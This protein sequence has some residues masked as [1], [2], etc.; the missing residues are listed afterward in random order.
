MKISLLLTLLPAASMAFTTPETQIIHHHPRGGDF[1]LQNTLDETA[2]SC[3]ST[4]EK[5]VGK[6]DDVVLNRAMR[7]V[8][9]AP[10]F[11]TLK[12]LAD[13]AG[14]ELGL[15]PAAISALLTGTVD[16]SCGVATAMA[17]PAFM[18]STV[19]KAYILFAGLSLA[20]SA[21]ANDSNELSQADITAATAANFAATRAIGSANGLRDSTILAI[22]SG[23]ALRNGSASGDP[24]IHNIAPQL[25]SSFST[26]LAILGL[27]SAVAAKIPMVADCS[28]LIELLGVGAYYAMV[29]RDGN[30]TV[31]KAVNAGILGGMLVNALKN[32]VTF[33]LNLGSLMGNVVLAAGAF[34]T[35]QA[36]D[37]LRNAV[38]S[39]DD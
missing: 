21:L 28:Q 10:A 2:D 8:D 27:V 13:A 17:V 39:G 9:H 25:L 1:A 30:G 11:F 35:Y 29:N 3:V 33:G 19:T 32:G 4:T 16:P 34:V 18:Y 7:I 36:V 22:V 12:A 15:S 23:Y 20:K 26:V 37:S 14:V 38:F 24:T 31:K 5:Y 6:A